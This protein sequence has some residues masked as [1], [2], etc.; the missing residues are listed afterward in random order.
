MDKGE[1]E[2]LSKIS[3][4]SEEVILATKENSER[5]VSEESD[6]IFHLMILLAS[7][8]IRLQEI[9]NEFDRRHIEKISK[10]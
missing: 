7:K 4:E 2:I 8:G 9:F 1:I 6:L 3:E 10:G 5:L